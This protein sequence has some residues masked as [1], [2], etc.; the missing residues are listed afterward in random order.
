MR[1]GDVSQNDGQQISVAGENLPR[2]TRQ[3]RAVEQG[4]AAPA[5]QQRGGNIDPATKPVPP[6]ITIFK[7][8]VPALGF[9]GVTLAITVVIQFPCR[10]YA[11]TTGS[12]RNSA[13][14]PYPPPA[15]PWA[16]QLRRRSARGNGLSLARPS[17]DHRQRSRARATAR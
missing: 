13:P 9:F 7:L 12:P 10:A 6:K 8:S 14:D 2:G 11:F 3:V 4:H 16:W 15:A 1:L 5:R 17:G